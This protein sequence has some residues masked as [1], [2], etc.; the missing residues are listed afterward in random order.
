MVRHVQHMSQPT[1]LL[2]L[3]TFIN[4]STRCT[5]ENSLSNSLLMDTPTPTH[6][7]YG[8]ET[9]I[10]EHLRTS[11]FRCSNR[12]SPT[13]IQ[14]N[15]LHL[16]LVFIGLELREVTTPSEFIQEQSKRNVAETSSTAHDRFRPSWGSSGRRSPRFSVNCMFH[17]NPVRT[18]SASRIYMYRDISNI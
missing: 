12:P 9:T 18:S 14:Q 17:V 15:S 8:S 5:T 13:A 2:V 11:Q 10:V 6:T 16:F 4:G 7:R 3:D 1:Q